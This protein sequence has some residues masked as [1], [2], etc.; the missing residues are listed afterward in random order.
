MRRLTGLTTSLALLLATAT[1]AAARPAD[2][3]PSS[4][5]G[6]RPQSLAQDAADVPENV[7]VSRIGAV[8]GAR[9]PVTDFSEVHLAASPVDPKHLIGSSKFFYDPA[10]YGFYTGVFESEDGGATWS[11]E[12]PP[13]VELYSLTSDPV[14]TF[15][16]QGNGY[17]TLLTR[18]PT[19]L[20]MLTKP[21]GKPW[22]APVVV[23]RTTVTDKQWIAGDQDLN[24][25]SRFP[26]RLY[27]S[28]TDVNS[29][30]RILVA[31]SADG[32]KTWSAP[33]ELDR[34]NL[35]GSQVA[36]GPDGTV[37]VLYGR[38]IF[39]SSVTGALLWTSSADGGLTWSK[40]AQ[41]A[42]TVSVPNHLDE[43]SDFRTP[44]S[45]PAFAI[46]PR[47]GTL[48]AA[49]ADF[50]SGD[51]DILMALSRDGGQNWSAARRVNDDALANGIDQIQPQLAAGPDGR[52][53]VAWLDRRNYCPDLRFIPREHVGK[54]DFCLDV[55][56]SRSVDDGATWT[57]NQRVS[58]QT[59]DWTLS[60]PRDGGGNGFIGDY[61]G[62]AATRDFDYPFWSGNADLGDNPTHRQQ[63]FTARVPAAPLP[64]DL[65]PSTLSVTPPA[66]APG[67]ELAV[68]L[69]LRNR[70]AAASTGSRAVQVLPA[71]MA[72]VPGSA[73][74]G[75]GQLTWDEPTRTLT[76][77]GPLAAG[78]SLPISYR[79]TLAADAA[80]GTVLDLQARLTDDAGRVYVRGAHATVSL[81]PQIVRVSP[82][83]GA[84]DVGPTTVIIVT[85]SEAMDPFSLRLATT[86]PLPEG[87]WEQPAWTANA[88]SVTLRH[89]LPFQSGTRY[90]LTLSAQ[91][92]SGLGLASGTVPNPW[93]FTVE[94][95]AETVRRLMLPWLG[96][97]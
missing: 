67:G 66:Q 57:T 29:P 49:W 71:G 38:D 77:N 89:G 72:L 63:V 33:L 80:E 19:G 15:D 46:S 58:A 54:E 41:A 69:T 10:A 61:I 35:Q 55:Y 88:K 31:H 1:V 16:H 78:A 45:L 28:W 50:R 24:E 83:D 23:D 40:P 70:G 26:G 12:Q 13:G 65:S 20:D 32:N 6:A 64:V 17:W 34:G 75:A 22:S 52:L 36:V 4:G 9:R 68:T 14:N 27:M 51:A 30:A 48:V 84:I 74:A 62:L 39:G 21:R 86:P 2:Q 47:T 37:T 53:V 73:Q 90:T 56:L 96:K 82:A 95:A 8:P 5:G 87:A 59:W 7:Q 44:A 94:K 11:Q 85:F 60:L 79:A 42:D 76:W 91:D 43:E 93:S 18:G 97:P 81:P 3:V 25:T 92:P